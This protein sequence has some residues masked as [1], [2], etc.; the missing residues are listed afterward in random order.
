MRLHA[1]YQLDNLGGYR[2]ATP[3]RKKDPIITY[4]EDEA[5]Y[6]IDIRTDIEPERV[7]SYTERILRENATLNL[8]SEGQSPLSLRT[9]DMV[10]VDMPY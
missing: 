10:I 9:L 7:K 2:S 5:L 6:T 8:A 3:P 4:K 1:T